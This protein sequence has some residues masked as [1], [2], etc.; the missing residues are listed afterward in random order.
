[1][2]LRTLFTAILMSVI[3]AGILAFPRTARPQTGAITVTGPHYRVVARAP[4]NQFKPNHYCNDLFT[5][6][7]PTQYSPQ[8]LSFYYWDPKSKAAVLQEVPM[9]D[10]RLVVVP[11]PK[12]GTAPVA[13]DNAAVPLPAVTDVGEDRGQTKW[14]LTV[15]QQMRDDDSNCLDVIRQ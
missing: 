14:I 11:N 1:M 13:L 8:Y 12:P 15:T 6:E 10:I 7:A 9:D 5:W 2:K 4:D 3:A